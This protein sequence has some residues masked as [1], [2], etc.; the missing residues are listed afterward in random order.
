VLSFDALEAF[1]VI[2]PTGD[3]VSCGG[4]GGWVGGC[5]LPPR[6]SRTLLRVTTF[7]GRRQREASGANLLEIRR[8]WLSS[9]MGGM[10]TAEALAF[11]LFP[12]SPAVA[13]SSRIGTMFPVIGFL[14]PAQT[15]HMLAAKYRLSSCRALVLHALEHHGSSTVHETTFIYVLAVLVLG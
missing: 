14:T 4:D 7:S 3:D 15:R 9:G 8:W 5:Q 11:F 1:C 2:G 10:T 6:G 12:E 13:L